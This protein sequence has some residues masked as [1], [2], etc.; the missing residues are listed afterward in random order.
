MDKQ[1][2]FISYSRLDSSF[3]NSLAADLKAHGANVWLDQLDIRPGQQWDRAIEQALRT[4]SEV[5]VVLS[6][7][8]VESNNVM[9]EIALALDER[10]TVIPV[11]YRECRIPFRLARVQYIDFRSDYE[12]GTTALIKAL[13]SKHQVASPG[14]AAPTLDETG[15]EKPDGQPGVAQTLKKRPV[16]NRTAAIRLALAVGIL[17]AGGL[18]VRNLI[19]NGDPPP[20]ERKVTASLK[21]APED[22]NGACPVSIKFSGVIH[23]SSAGPV[24]YRMDRSD[25]ASGPVQTI[26]F[27]AP[28][29][30]NVEDAWQLGGPQLPQ[31]AGWKQIVILSPAEAKSNRAAF[32]ISC[33]TPPQPKAMI[34]EENTTYDGAQYGVFPAANRGGCEA[35][36]VAD[37]K[38]QAYTFQRALPQSQPLCRLRSAVGKKSPNSC[39]DS[40]RKRSFVTSD[41]LINPSILSR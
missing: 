33:T 31:F 19:K 39:C 35:A 27:D 22:H 29:D 24:T 32:K 1:P 38:C 21:A 30:R 34:L 10:K 5:I 36:C 4:A 16:L 13:A 40:A 26:E 28:G 6:P 7:A 41:V 15:D 37:R 14:V 3:A 12:A 17:V 2:A 23:N 20:P 9:D 25:G 11:L 18:V 8:A